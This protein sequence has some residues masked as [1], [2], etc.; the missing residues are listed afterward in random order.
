M[1]KY[2]IV[3]NEYKCT[4]CNLCTL[5]CNRY[6]N[7]KLGIKNSKITIKGKSSRYKIEI[8]YGRQIEYPEKIKEICPH[9]CFDLIKEK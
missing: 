9:D 4:G 6:E 7:N 8:D 5:A 3:S 1:K 2:L